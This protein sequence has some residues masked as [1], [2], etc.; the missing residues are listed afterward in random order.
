LRVEE[1]THGS[2]TAINHFNQVARFHFGIRRLERKYGEEQVQTLFR[3]EAL[4]IK[5]ERRRLPSNAAA[6]TSA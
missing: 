5:Q 4:A 1:K 2:Q 6:E 3:E